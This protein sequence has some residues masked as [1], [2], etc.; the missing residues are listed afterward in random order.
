LVLFVDG[1]S[2]GCGVPAHALGLLTRSPLVLMFPL[3]Q[4]NLRRE[5]R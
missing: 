2:C 3:V 1:G 5:T 4:M